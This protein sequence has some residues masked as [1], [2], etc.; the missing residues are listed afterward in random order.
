MDLNTILKKLFGAERDYDASSA[1]QAGLNLDPTKHGVSR[2]PRGPKEGLLL[3][4]PFHETFY[5]TVK[6]EKK[7]GYQIYEDDKSKRL[8]S[9]PQERVMPTNYYPVKDPLGNNRAGGS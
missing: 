8:Y 7:A 6:G 3:K 4:S 2:I 1:N 9:F 5:K